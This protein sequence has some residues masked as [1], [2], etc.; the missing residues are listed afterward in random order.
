MRIVL[1][2]PGAQSLKDRRRIIRSFKERAASRLRVT[3]AEVGDVE[4]VQLATLGFVT[5]TRESSECHRIL[6]DVRK[7]A[8]TLP[9]AMLLDVR[10]EVLSMGESG[11]ELQGGIEWLLSD[12]EGRNLSEADDHE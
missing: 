1:R 10:G 3:V 6:N 9:E 5:V 4:R 11:S 2:V 8:M 7:M 12:A